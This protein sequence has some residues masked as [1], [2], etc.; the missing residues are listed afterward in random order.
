M[1]RRRRE[2]STLITG[3]P[4]EMGVD[5]FVMAEIRYFKSMEMQVNRCEGMAL[6]F[7]FQDL[8]AVARLFAEISQRYPQLRFLIDGHTAVT[9]F[10]AG[11]AEEGVDLAPFG[12]HRPTEEIYSTF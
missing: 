6:R 12:D 4:D 1:R 9:A 3:F 8:D 11:Q 2:T 7:D 5:R 10:A